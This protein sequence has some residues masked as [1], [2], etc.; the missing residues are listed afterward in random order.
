VNAVMTDKPPAARILSR[1]AEPV[2]IL[3]APCTFSWAVCAMFGE[4]PEMYA[5]PEC[6]LFSASTVGEWLELCTVTTFEMDHGLV[7][8]IAELYFGGQSD[9]TASRARG[10]LQRRSHFTT[11]LLL[12]TIM[13]R[14]K[15]LIVVE[16]SPSIVHRV[17]MMQLAREMFP[18]ARFVHLVSHPRLHGRVVMQNLRIAQ[19]KQPLPPSHWLVELASPRLSGATGAAAATELDPQFSWLAANQRISQ[20]LASVPDDQRT[21]VRGEELIAD[22]GESRATIAAWLSLRSDGE[23]VEAMR[24][25]ERSPY[26]RRGPPSAPFGSDAFLREGPLL[27][28]D[29]GQQ[30]SLDGPLPWRGDDLGFVPE[31]R[32]LAQEFGYV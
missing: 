18:S 26:A 32:Q 24:H 21:V 12:E 20:F 13:E 10:W 23:A 28:A 27:A 31:V 8:T 2:L 22:E 25:P 3:A 4:H 11:G 14:L 15:P 19:S 7:R 1:P 29:W 9:M 6:H 30:R 17:E 16:K 5:L